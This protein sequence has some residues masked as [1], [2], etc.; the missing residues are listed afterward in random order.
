MAA[1]LDAE[2]KACGH[3]WEALAFSWRA[4]PHPALPGEDW[5]QWSCPRCSSSVSIPQR[6]MRR[7]WRR[8]VEREWASCDSRE[9]CLIERI[10]RNMIGGGLWLPANV[11]IGN[12]DCLEC[13]FAMDTE[14][15]QHFRLAC[16]LCGSAV[17]VEGC[18]I[19]TVVRVDDDTEVE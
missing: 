16:P 2:C 11:E 1:E 9:R 12:V 14:S 8:W 19:V 18:A 17:V 6:V 3:R 13:G 15:H 7:N 10:D 4:G 5:Q